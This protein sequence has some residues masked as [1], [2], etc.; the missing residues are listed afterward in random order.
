MLGTH[1]H[2]VHKAT[3][4]DPLSVTVIFSLP[5]ILP[6]PKNFLYQMQRWPLNQ[7]KG[8]FYMQQISQFAAIPEE[9]NWLYDGAVN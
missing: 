9:K 4:S 8:K 1:C 3:Q 2:H 7:K 6:S 5:S